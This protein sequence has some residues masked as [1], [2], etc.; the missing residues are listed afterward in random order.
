MA[1]APFITLALHPDRLDS[2]AVERWRSIT[3]EALF[4]MNPQVES[5]LSCQLAS[6]LERLL[7]Y[8]LPSLPSKTI[9]ELVIQ[10]QQTSISDIARLA[11]DLSFMIQH[12]VLS[13]RSYVTTGPSLSNGRPPSVNNELTPT[14]GTDGNGGD[15]ESNFTSTWGK[16]GPHDVI[17]GSYAFGL[18]RAIGFERT[19]LIVPKMSTTVPFHLGVP[20][21]ANN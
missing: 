7:Q 11:R 5:H 3:V 19:V 16:M 8:G 18:E 4:S 20:P 14:A 21:H 2:F 6:E 17:L 9:S 1:A 15:V 13:C 12:D 10:P